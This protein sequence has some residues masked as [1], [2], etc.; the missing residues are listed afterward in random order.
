VEL[1]VIFFSMFVVGYAYTKSLYRALFLALSVHIAGNLLAIHWVGPMP[2]AKSVIGFRTQWTPHQFMSV[3]WLNTLSAAALL[4]IW[5]AGWFGGT[6][7]SWGYAALAAAF[8]WGIQAMIFKTAGWFY[9]PFDILTAGLPASTLT[10]LWVGQ[11]FSKHKMTS[12]R[13]RV[14]ICIIFLMQ[15]AVMGPIYFNTIKINS[16]PL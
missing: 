1:L 8:V 6:K 9:R 14:A 10:F 12:G 5:R 7:R 3:L 16:S 15:M 2:C 4:V 13:A 11:S